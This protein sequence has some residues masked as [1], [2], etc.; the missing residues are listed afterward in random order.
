MVSRQIQNPKDTP[1]R[2]QRTDDGFL[3]A[4]ALINEYNS[5]VKG[6]E[7][8]DI[9]FYRRNKSTSEYVKFLEEKYN[10]RPIVASRKGTWMHP[11]LF[12]DF[13]MWI[14]VEFKDMAIKWILDGLI[15]ERNDAGDY[16]NQLKATIIERYYEFHGCKPSPM[17]YQNEFKMIKECAGFEER[18]T[19]TEQQ[20]KALNTLQLLDIQLIKEKVGKPSRER[21]LKQL[22]TALLAG[23]SN[24]PLALK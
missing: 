17:I 10:V 3:N 21:Q 7:A 6:S 19:A 5:T 12:I 15:Q 14:S 1:L 8:K 20:L 9:Q 11:H 18:N 23:E 2:F 16:A 22:S 4:T 24:R 13:A